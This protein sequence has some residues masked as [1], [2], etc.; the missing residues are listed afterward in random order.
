[1]DYANDVK[2]PLLIDEFIKCVSMMIVPNDQMRR[3]LRF[4]QAPDIDADKTDPAFG[5]FLKVLKHYECQQDAGELDQLLKILK[6]S[7]SLLEIGSAFGGCL[8]RM[9]NVLAP[10]SMIVSVDMPTAAENELDAF[11]NSL[12]PVHSLKEA[13]SHINLAMGHHVELFIGNSREQQ[14]VDAVRSLGPFD[15]CFIDGDHSYEGVKADWE[16]YGPMCKIVAFHDIAGAVPGCVKFWTEMLASKQ[17]RTA[18]FVNYA[19]GYSGLGIG[20]VFREEPS[21]P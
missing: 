1:M 11:R 19:N 20:V 8:K 18:E 7:K 6:G 13:C 14:I 10:R 15:F 5:R 21:Q 12:H 9:A 3:S 17:Y 2:G 16:N 4:Y